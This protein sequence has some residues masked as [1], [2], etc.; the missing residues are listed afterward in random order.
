MKNTELAKTERL[1]LDAKPTT[2]GGAMAMIEQLIAKGVT[3][4]N[5]A[6][7]KELRGMY[8]DE[9]ERHAKRAFAEAFRAMQNELPAIA[10]TKIVPN[11]DGSTRFKYAPYDE[12]MKTVGPVMQKHGFSATF[13][14]K[15]NEGRVTSVC[16]LIHDL[17][18]ERTNEYSVRIGSGPPGATESQADGAANQYA[19]RGALSDALNLV[20]LGR[21]N[22]A[23][24]LGASVTHD[25]AE[26]LRQRVKDAKLNEGA[27]LKWA[28]APDYETIPATR[29][30]R[31]SAYLK[32][33]GY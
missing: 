30:E 20:I 5:V 33:K 6:A 1:D 16:T 22:D 28:G 18:H 13:S 2:G 12:L 27:F 3:S 8:I 23:R 29:Y 7:L 10:P 32:E 14:T 19:Q 11:K 17:G 21:E 25:Q 4:D 26:D 24:D 15:F 31:L 9:E